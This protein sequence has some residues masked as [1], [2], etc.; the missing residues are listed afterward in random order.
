[1]DGIAANSVL[2]STSQADLDRWFGF[3]IPEALARL[4]HAVANP[5]LAHPQPQWMGRVHA[6]TGMTLSNV[7]RTSV[8]PE[9]FVFGE[10][11]SDSTLLGC[12]LHDPKLSKDPPLATFFPHAC[13]GV[14]LGPDTRRGVGAMLGVW[15]SQLQADHEKTD[16]VDEAI[17]RMGFDAS[18]LPQEPPLGVGLRVP[19]GWRYAIS[20][21]GLG[22][23]A[24]TQQFAPD[25][26]F[27]A[28]PESLAPE[29]L[30][31]SIEQADQAIEANHPATALWILRNAYAYSEID[32]SE[33]ALRMPLHQAY[34][35]LNRV[36][37]ARR[38][39]PPA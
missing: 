36:E 38:V 20:A 33:Q 21:D 1:M 25:Q 28:D 9:L 18:E 26:D 2:A 10:V 27:N 11:E 15:R 13:K 17:D 39:L 37:L 30:S 8:P 22:V 23:V 35:A 12:V 31:A 4:I 19:P 14:Y 3:A 7:R 5:M 34:L 24:K 29:E 6:A 32:Q 16:A